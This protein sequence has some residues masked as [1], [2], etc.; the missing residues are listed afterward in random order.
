M[1]NKYNIDDK[2]IDC[3]FCDVDKTKLE[4]TVLEETKYFYITPSLG[5]IVEGYILII[6]KRHI[7]AMSELNKEEIEEY[8]FLIE[9]YRKIKAMVTDKNYILYISPNDKIYITNKFKSV[10]QLMRIEIAKN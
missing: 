9:K 7:K 8:E 4:N 2:S 1:K 10:S 3:P 5:A 6:V